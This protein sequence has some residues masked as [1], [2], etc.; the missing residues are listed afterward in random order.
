MEDQQKCRLKSDALLPFFNFFTKQALPKLVSVRLG[1][2]FGE[3]MIQ[4]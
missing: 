3:Q 1:F 2:R 4:T